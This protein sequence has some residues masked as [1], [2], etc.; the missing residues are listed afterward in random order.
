MMMMMSL[1]ELREERNRAAR[2][3]VFSFHIGPHT[4]H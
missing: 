1:T 3:L 4:E 2:C